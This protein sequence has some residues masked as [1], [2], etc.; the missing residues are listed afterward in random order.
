MAKE[1]AKTGMGPT[2]L[3]AMEQYFPQKE[4]IVKDEFAYKM[5]P[6]ILK[7]FVRLTKYNWLRKWMI[8]KMEKSFPGLYASMMCRKRYIDE[9]II[10]SA[11]QINAVVNLGAGFDTRSL[12]IPQLSQ[13]PIWELDQPE[14]VQ[15]KQKRLKEIFGTIPLHIKLVSI[16]FDH[17]D[18]GTVLS[19]NDFS[20]NIKTFFVW[21]AVTQYLT[22]KGIRSTFDY[23]AKAVSGSRLAFT[24]VRK[25]FIDGTEVFNWENNYKRFVKDNKI[26]LFGMEVGAWSNFMKEYGWRVIEDVDYE[27]LNK[28]YIEPIGRV[29]ST[30]PVERLVYAEKI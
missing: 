1:A 3:I 21:E 29:L 7:L 26:W 22:E 12:R 6:F 8:S 17:Q 25:D 28:K 27:E 10:N 9:K 19:S 15:Q 4:R 14:N 13:I 20:N 23:L 2:T 30:T 24:Y 5:H 16:D 18:L 11:N